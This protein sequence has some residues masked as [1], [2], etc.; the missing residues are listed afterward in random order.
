MPATTVQDVHDL[1]SL[2]KFDSL[3]TNQTTPVFELPRTDSLRSLCSTPSPTPQ[4]TSV[5]PVQ[6]T[7]HRLVTPYLKNPQTVE[8]PT[9]NSATTQHLVTPIQSHS[10]SWLIPQSITAP[11]LT[12]HTFCTNNYTVRLT[13]PFLASSNSSFPGTLSMTTTDSHSSNF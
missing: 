13:N 2:S 4:Q 11:P 7:A 6:S 8:L 12:W 1:L 5:V 10:N 3:V 9:N